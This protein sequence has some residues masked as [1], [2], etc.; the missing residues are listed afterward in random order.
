MS[1]AAVG[2]VSLL[3]LLLVA[4]AGSSQDDHSAGSPEAASEPPLVT[5]QDASTAEPSADQAPR[6]AAPT[7]RPSPESAPTT[8]SPAGEARVTIGATGDLLAHESVI[9]SAAA[10]TEGTAYDFSPMFAEVNDL[11]REPDLSLCHLETPLSPDNTELSRTGVFTFNAPHE[12]AD[13]VAG[14]GWDGCEFASNHTMDRGLSGLAETERIVREAGLGY[15]GPTADRERAGIPETYDV[16]GTQVAH[17]AYTY[18]YPNDGSPTTVVPGKAPWLERNLWPAIGAG[19][20]LDDSARARAE[21]AAFV[22]VSMHWGQEYLTEPT[23]Q[24]RSLARELLDSGDVDLILGTQ[25]HVVQ[26]CEKVNGRYVFYGLG[27]FL[28]NQSPDTTG[29]NLVTETQEGMVARIV[30]TRTSDGAVR[31]TARY[32]PTRVDLDGHVVR[33]VPP[34]SATYR[35]TVG[36]VQLLGP[37]AC[38]A[39]PMP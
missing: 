13:A 33:P 35:R 8:G 22:V 24:Q 10:N 20:I 36:A 2:A 28:S 11:L 26:P 32:Q 9:D 15:A 3:A 31:S 25:V 23:E 5:A 12:L 14:A 38:D 16:R 4:C 34:D 19:G 17:L 6:T 1:R 7:V 27:N 18:T 39:R 37:N 29:A 21:G 30:L